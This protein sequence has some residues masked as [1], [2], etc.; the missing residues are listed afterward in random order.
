ML[1][2]VLK[3]DNGKDEVVWIEWFLVFEIIAQNDETSIIHTKRK[4]HM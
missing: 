1:D 3:D 2:F 4:K